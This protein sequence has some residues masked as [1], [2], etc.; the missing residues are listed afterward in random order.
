MSAEEKDRM[1]HI[2]LDEEVH[3]DLRK[4]AAEEDTSMQKLV[5]KVVSQTVSGGKLVNIVSVSGVDAGQEQ[6]ISISMAE[7]E[8][9]T[10]LSL[11][12]RLAVLEKLLERMG[13]EVV[14]I[15]EQIRNRDE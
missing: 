4:A 2:R 8:Q 12:E 5:S 14:K 7:E 11:S 9:L 3:K 6:V 15:R 10:D 1:I 13:I